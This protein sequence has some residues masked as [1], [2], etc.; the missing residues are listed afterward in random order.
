MSITSL[1]RK[2]RDGGELADEEILRI[3]EGAAQGTIPDYQLSAFLMAVYFAGMTPHETARLT[4]AMAASGSRLDLSGIDLPKVDKHSTGGVGDKVSLILGPI[5]ASHGIAVPMIAG[6]SL[7]HT[8][9]TADKLESIPGFHSRLPLPDI[10]RQ[11]A[12]IGLVMAAQSDALAPADGRLYALRDVTATVE[13][14]PLITAS[15]LSK[16]LAENLDALVM[17]VKTGR[18]AFMASSHD[19]RL[20]AESIRSVSAAN[21]LRCTT[22]ITRMDAPLGRRIGNW[23]EV[24]EA[25]RALRGEEEPPLLMEVTYALAGACIEAAGRASTPEEG[26]DLARRSIDDG[27]AY[28]KFLEVVRRQGGDVAAVEHA[29][30]P[31]PTEVI[32][33]DR[34]GYITAIDALRLGLVAIELGAGRHALHDEIAPQA[35]IILLR[36][37]G[38]HVSRGEA[39]CAVVECRSGVKVDPEDLRSCFTIEEIAVEMPEMVVA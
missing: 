35:G 38:D 22:L 37:L 11:V 26:I 13:S 31:Q 8:G 39:L 5:V 3:V 1:I 28:A 10:E 33:S 12:E 18:G 17:D 30:E 15:I 25:V 23:L 32:I 34:A 24:C 20:L 9:G 16:K 21:G 14:L 36:H 4:A 27:S 29:R 2:K 7:G 6:R 19:A